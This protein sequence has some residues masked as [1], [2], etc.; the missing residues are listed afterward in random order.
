MKIFGRFVA[1][2]FLGVSCWKDE[3]DG[4]LRRDVLGW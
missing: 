2:F 3:H 4:F 1:R